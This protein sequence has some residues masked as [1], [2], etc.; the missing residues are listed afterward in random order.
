MNLFHE[1]YGR[2][3]RIVSML[4]RE[5]S[6]TDAD[7]RKLT[8]AEGFRE[9]GLFLPQK[10]IPQED[11]S[12]WGLFQRIDNGRLKPLTKHLPVMPVTA[13]Q[14]R[15]LRAKLDDPRL[16]LFLDDAVYE[17]LLKKLRGVQP[18]FR[19]EWFRFPDRFTDGD[20]Y[21]DAA[22]REHFRT[23][24]AALNSGKALTIRYFSGKGAE[25]V[26][27][28]LPL[29]LEYSA[30]NDKF[31]LFCIQIKNGMLKQSRTVN[32]GRI[33]SVVQTDYAEKGVKS[34]MTPAEF[35]TRT[36]ISSLN[37]Q[38]SAG[39]GVSSAPSRC[40]VPVTVRVT[41]V[42]S[43][44]ERFLMEFA[45]YQKQ[46]ERDPVSGSCTVQLWYDKQ[47]E[48]EV[49]IRLLS[50]GPVLEILDPPAFRQQAAD[51]IRKQLQILE[52]D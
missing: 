3:F 20:P 51:R 45:P 38:Q 32:L 1:M 42:R 6:C 33:R 5:E 29:Y 10:L 31:R 41:E 30:K 35:R 43:G 39:A 17:A 47:D 8:S 11:G 2:Y 46:T 7:I 13:I 12:D 24:L 19:P 25:V 50:F 27:Q 16:R 22:Y 9:S 26:L 18:L 21:T 40:E 34:E 14:K 4:L 52:S 37:R 28:C 36:L 48:V 44:V 23:I 49:L 15:W